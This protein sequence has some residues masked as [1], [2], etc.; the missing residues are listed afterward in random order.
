MTRRRVRSTLEILLMG[1]EIRLKESTSREDRELDETLE[2][3]F[4]ASD[5][6]ANTVE[7]GIR[8]GEP[9]RSPNV[10]VSDKDNPAQE[11]PTRGEPTDS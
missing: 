9:A 10:P 3:T 7:T 5:A 4:P 6:P 11:G 1:T 2:E 8:I